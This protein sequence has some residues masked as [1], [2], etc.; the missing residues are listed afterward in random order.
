MKM[1]PKIFGPVIAFYDGS[2]T[3]RYA[4]DLVSDQ[5]PHLPAG[6]PV[7]MLLASLAYC[8]VKSVEW[9]AKEHNSGLLPFAVKVTGTKAL[10]LPGRVEQMEVLIIG[11]LVAD[12]AVAGQIV[13]LAK[14]ICTVSNTLNCAVTV[15][16][17]PAPDA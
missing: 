8:I 7:D 14:S 10:D 2:D 6:S 15:A 17:E 1:K 13:K 5:S 4:P 3:T 9:A 11:D 12:F 16:T